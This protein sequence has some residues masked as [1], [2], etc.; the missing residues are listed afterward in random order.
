MSIYRIRREHLHT[1]APGDK[2]GVVQVKASECGVVLKWIGWEHLPIVGSGRPATVIRDVR[3]DPD[4]PGF[5]L[6][7]TADVILEINPPGR[8]E[9]EWRV[10]DCERV[11]RVEKP[12]KP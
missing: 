6:C 1:D 8:D 11:D 9:G 10:V 2:P 3:A 12:K 4:H 7:E 5:L